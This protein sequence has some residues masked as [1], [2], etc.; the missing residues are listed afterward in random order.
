MDFW[1]KRFRNIDAP[2][3]NMQALDI[4]RC[5]PDTA[6]ITYLLL[7]LER[8]SPGAYVRDANRAA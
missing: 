8:R 1:T 2:I 3:I 7:R 4:T 5:H 6:T